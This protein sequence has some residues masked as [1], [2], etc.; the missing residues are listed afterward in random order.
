MTENANGID[1]FYETRGSGAPLVLLHGNGEDHRIFDALAA[2]LGAHYTLY[3]IDSRNHGKSARHDDFSYAAM[4]E[5]IRAFIENRHLAPTNVLGFSDGAIVAL[6][7][8]M[9]HPHTLRRMALAGVNLKPGDF[10]A[11]SR[12]WIEATY[13]ETGDPLF[14]LMLE[15]PDIETDALRDVRIPALVV[16]GEHDIYRPGLFAEIAAALPDAALQIAPGHTHDSYIA[17][18]DLL[19]PDLVRFFG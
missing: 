9:R 10:T 8:A 11:E 19:Y 17:H 6:M 4:A 5:D 2:R 15:E 18:S 14:R 7:L 1:L 13:R 3:A 12:K 16:G